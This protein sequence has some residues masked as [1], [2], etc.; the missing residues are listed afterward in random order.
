MDFFIQNQI[1]EINENLEGKWFLVTFNIPEKRRALRN[2]LREQLKG[3]GFGRLHS[4]LWISPY[5][6]K[7]ECGRIIK[8]LGLEEYVSMFMTDYMGKDDRDLAFRTWELNRLSRI[9]EKFLISYRKKIQDFKGKKFKDENEAAMEALLRILEF[10]QDVAEIAEMDPM[11]PKELLPE[12]WVGIEMEKVVFEYLGALYQK[13][14][15]IIEFGY[16]F[17]NKKT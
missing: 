5:N 15:S 11:L 2:R 17:G 7:T 3:L 4:N 10:K 9:Y 6:L 14:S 12:D 13:A 16:L 8:E 1:C